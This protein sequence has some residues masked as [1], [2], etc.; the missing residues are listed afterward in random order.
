MKTAKP[1]LGSLLHGLRA[2]NGWTLREMSDRTGI[3]F[4]TLSKVECDRLTLTYDKLQQLCERL[5]I[6]M[7]DLFA[8]PDD[9]ATSTRV[10]AR[11]SVGTLETA[12]QVRT[13][14]YDYFY[15][16]PDLRQKRML[17]MVGSLRAKSVE[18]FGELVRHAGEE[19]IYVLEGA[20]TVHTEFY[21][22]VTLRS[23]EMMYIDSNMGHAYVVADGYDKAMIVGAC[24]SHA[25]HLS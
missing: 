21:E 23:G 1:T 18:D 13:N 15:F 12:V 22:P 11:R 7:S 16:C 3:P 19:F 17:P 6:R 20:V 9:S 25:E 8:E 4:S 24:S 14:N 2:R 5:H 10:T